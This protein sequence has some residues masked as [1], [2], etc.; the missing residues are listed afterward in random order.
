MLSPEPHFPAIHNGIAAPRI[1][2]PNIPIRVIGREFKLL[3]C[4]NKADN[5]PAITTPLTATMMLCVR[6]LPSK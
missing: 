5:P 3:L 4:T 6:F 2:A 1:D